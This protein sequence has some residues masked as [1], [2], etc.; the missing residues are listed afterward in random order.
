MLT[1]LSQ[2]EIEIVSERRKFGLNGAMKAGHIPGKCPIGYYRDKTLKIDNSTKDVVFRIFEMYLEGK[3][4]QTI[5]N[6][7][8]KEKVLYPEV[9]LL[10]DSSIN[11]II[12]NK[13]YV[14]DY[15]R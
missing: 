7:L 15:E 14:G 4:Y 6:I 3:S 1:V 2:L 5:A 13:K 8:N 9:K 11:R 10:I 12:N